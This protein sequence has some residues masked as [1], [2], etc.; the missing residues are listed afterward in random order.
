M[1]GPPEGP[2]SHP[3]LLMSSSRRDKVVTSLRHLSQCSNWCNTHLA[4][5][6]DRNVTR[7][8]AT[9]RITCWCLCRAVLYAQPIVNNSKLYIMA[10]WHGYF[11]TRYGPCHTGRAALCPNFNS[12]WPHFQCTCHWGSSKQVTNAWEFSVWRGTHLGVSENG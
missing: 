3:D 12:P 1:L 10:W 9:S 2:G 8:Q 6:V 7:L 5:A 4:I 11:Q